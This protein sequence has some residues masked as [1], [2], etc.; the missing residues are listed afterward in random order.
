MACWKNWTSR[1][2][3]RGGKGEAHS[4][5]PRR[6]VPTGVFCCRGVCFTGVFCCKGAY[7]YALAAAAAGA[8]S[9]SVR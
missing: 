5:H 6:T 7:R 8:L 1:S 9:S 2:A 3:A 4:K